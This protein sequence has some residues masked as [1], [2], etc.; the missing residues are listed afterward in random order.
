[1][2]ATGTLPGVVEAV[3]RATTRA[4]DADEL[5]E[6]VATEVRKVIPYDGVMWFGV[7][8]A[9]LLAVAPARMEHMNDGYCETFWHGESHDREVAVFNAISPVV[10]RALRTQAALSDRPARCCDAPGL[11]LFDRSGGLLSANDAA[12]CWL[13]DIYGYDESTNWFEV[14]VGLDSPDLDGVWR[15]S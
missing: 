8:P 10:A 11:M 3:E 13:A 1:M 15:S 12:S 7:D 14:L 2:G 6:A 4:A 9:T 5:L